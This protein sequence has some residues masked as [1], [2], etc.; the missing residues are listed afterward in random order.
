MTQGLGEGCCQQAV[1]T[2]LATKSIG[3][4]VGLAGMIVNLQVI[5]FYQLLPSPLAHVEVGLSE[6]VLE[7][8]VVGVDVAVGAHQIV[9]PYL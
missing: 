2:V 7:A 4:H 6:D 8:L 3:H 1:A 9:S 5:V